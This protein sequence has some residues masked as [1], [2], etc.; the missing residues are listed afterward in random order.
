M[1]ADG[2]IE[3]RGIARTSLEIVRE[4]LMI[5]VTVGRL[6]HSSLCQASVKAKIITP[7]PSTRFEDGGVKQERGTKIR[8]FHI[9][10]NIS[11]HLLVR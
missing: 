6:V 2:L 8:K 5:I 4:R 10:L 3:G 1:L 11:D 7:L 9:T